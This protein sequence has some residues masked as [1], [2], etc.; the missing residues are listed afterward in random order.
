MSHAE[1]LRSQD[2]LIATQPDAAAFGYRVDI[3]TEYWRVQ[4][5]WEK[6]AKVGASTTLQGSCWLSAF[7]AS[8]GRMPGVEPVLATVSDSLSGRD[9]LGLPLIRSK[10]G[11]L[12]VVEFADHGMTDYNAPIIGSLVPRDL[13]N[14]REIWRALRR[15]LPSCDLVSFDRMPKDIDGVLNPLAMLDGVH[16]SSVNRYLLELPDDWDAWRNGLERR[17]RRE[18]DGAWRSFC[19]EETASF[20][21]LSTL[22]DARDMFFGLKRHQKSSVVDLTGPFFM[23]QP[24]VR[25]FYEKLFI[26]GLSERSVMLSTLTMGD[27]PIA[28][29]LGLVDG[30]T[31]TLVHLATAGGRWKM[32]LPGRLVIERTMQALHQQGYRAFDFTTGEYPYKRMFGA[33]ALPLVDAHIAVSWRA[34][35][36]VIGARAKQVIGRHEGLRNTM[37]TLGAYR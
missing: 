6:L 33:S 32:Y 28:T 5:R 17:F 3:E 9:L 15:A 37:H 25:L 12:R 19:H 27:E 26:G 16:G 29:L 36:T 30:N 2:S 14:V 18:L 21:F 23:D 22:Q 20:R 24:S 7:Y 8:I 1:A 4:A 31:Y 35:P 34:L 11:R 10:H 13:R